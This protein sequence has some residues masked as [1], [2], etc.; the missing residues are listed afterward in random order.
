MHPMEPFEN[1]ANFIEDVGLFEAA[2]HAPATVLPI[3]QPSRVVVATD[4]SNQDPATRAVGRMIA[5]RFG[6][7]ADLRE[8][9][10]ARELDAIHSGAGL[11]VVPVPFGS[12]IGELREE[13]L[14]PAVD[15]LLASRA[16]PLLAV[17]QPLADDLLAAALRNIVVPLVPGETGNDLALGWACHFLK[18]GGVLTVLENADREVLAEARLLLDGV[19]VSDSTAVATIERVLNRQFAGLI[20]AVQRV[21]ADVGFETQVASAGGR[22]VDSVL[23]RV[24]DAPTLAIVSCARDR[25]AANYHRVADLILASRYPVLVV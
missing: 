2:V 17:R 1:A 8:N 14:G 24:G 18:G 3:I 5:E 13:S 7:S 11:L 25:R 22:F 4:G 23:A 10:P 20:G 15:H 9:L 12:D 16:C 21:S 19:N 6:Q